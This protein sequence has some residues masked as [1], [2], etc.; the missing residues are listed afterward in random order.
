MEPQQLKLRSTNCHLAIWLAIGFISSPLCYC[1][2]ALGQ[3]HGRD[4]QNIILLPYE[5]LGRNEVNRVPESRFLSDPR[6]SEL[7]QT[8]VQ[9]VRSTG[10]KLVAIER[11]PLQKLQMVGDEH[12]AAMENLF[13][14]DH[15]RCV[16]ARLRRDSFRYAETKK[17]D[18]KRWPA[19]QATLLR[20]RFPLDEVPSKED[21]SLLPLQCEVAKEM[22]QVCPFLSPVYLEFL[23]RA[24]K[25]NSEVG[26]PHTTLTWLY[27]PH[28]AL[29][30]EIGPEYGVA[31]GHASLVSETLLTLYGERFHCGEHEAEHLEDR[32][33]KISKS[34]PERAPELLK[35]WEFVSCELCVIE[36]RCRQGKF[37][38]A[39][40]LASES[41]KRLDAIP[42]DCWEA[43]QVEWDAK[44]K[45]LE[46]RISQGRAK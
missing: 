42:K 41:R 45:D 35:T 23:F 16:V 10:E 5:R 3:E 19:M 1:S 13:P 25:T 43:D 31:V 44:L 14:K 28:V 24:A 15:W 21:P 26:V 18:S 40:Q 17:L 34:I 22:S 4:E 30:A 38:S 46:M 29:E 12:A 39:M 32:L 33:A 37:D 27:H 8:V 6:F 36:S 9:K 7:D 2:F 11:H 20:S